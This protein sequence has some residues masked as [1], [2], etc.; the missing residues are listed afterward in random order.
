MDIYSPKGRSLFDHLSAE[1]TLLN[2]IQNMTDKVIVYGGRGGLGIVIVDAFKVWQPG[3]QMVPTFISGCRLLGVVSRPCSQRCRWCQCPCEFQLISDF[4]K[5]KRVK[6]TWTSYEI[7]NLKWNQ[8]VATVTKLNCWFL[9][10]Y[11]WAWT[12]VGWI[13]RQQSAKVLMTLSGERRLVEKNS[14]NFLQKCATRTQEVDSTN[15]K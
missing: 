3:F 4:D 2:R 9:V 7:W 12:M 14:N 13:R 11:R 15:W 6:S 1:E 8:L 10:G 5:S